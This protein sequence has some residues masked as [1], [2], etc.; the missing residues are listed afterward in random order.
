MSQVELPLWFFSF[1]FQKSSY[2][3]GAYPRQFLNHQNAL[4]EE[5]ITDGETG[6]TQTIH[7][8]YT[9]NKS[10]YPVS[11]DNGEESMEIRY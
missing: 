11:I 9:Y 3:T 4:T 5:T 2:S 6:N 8:K 10:S 7:Y 1:W